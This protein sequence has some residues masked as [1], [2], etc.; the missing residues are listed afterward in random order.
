MNHSMGLLKTAVVLL[1]TSTGLISSAAA[2]QEPTTGQPV[3]KVN[4]DIRAKLGMGV[5]SFNHKEFGEC[6]TGKIISDDDPGS[7]SVTYNLELMRSYEE[8]QRETTAEAS[9][10]T[11]VASFSAKVK[12]KYEE[13]V[14]TSSSTQFLLVKERVLYN[15]SY[16][17]RK[18]KLD[19][20]EPLKKGD[21]QSQAEFF[22]RC[23]DEYVSEVQ[24]GG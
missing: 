22:S 18:V 15:P 5:N 6:V 17:F 1:L 16:Y 24:N 20:D 19:Y 23:G 13:S 8:F 14:K 10:S 21:E 12:S 2:Q 11:D 9:F 7:S 4:A 3:A